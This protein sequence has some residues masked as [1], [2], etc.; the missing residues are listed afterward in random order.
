MILKELIDK[1]GDESENWLIL[2]FLTK[3][4]INELKLNYLLNVDDN[5]FLDIKHKR[6]NS[7]PL[8]YIFAMGVFTDWNYL[9]MSQRLFLDLKRKF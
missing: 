4:K 3:R 7:Y 8:Q 1:F 9:L 2:E 6:E 5:E